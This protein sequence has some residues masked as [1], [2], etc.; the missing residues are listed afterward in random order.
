MH[1]VWG[2]GSIMLTLWPLRNTTPDTIISISRR[3]TTS[4]ASGYPEFF[5]NLFRP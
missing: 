5:L 3:S 1:N 4:D 2:V